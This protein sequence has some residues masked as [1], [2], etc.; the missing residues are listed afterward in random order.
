MKYLIIV[1]IM[2]ILLG[3][4]IFNRNLELMTVTNLNVTGEELSNYIK[5]NKLHLTSDTHDTHNTHD[6]H[7]TH[8]K[9]DKH[10]RHDTHDTHDIHDK[11]N[12]LNNKIIDLA[13]RVSKIEKK[14]F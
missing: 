11:V 10:D 6:T 9:H 13:N 3:L 14:L 12:D 7:D 2:T 5:T 8:D 1:V 4:F